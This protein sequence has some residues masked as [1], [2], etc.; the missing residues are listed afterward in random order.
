MKGLLVGTVLTLSLLVI[1]S[2]Q[3]KELSVAPLN[4]M[5]SDSIT[6]EVA[7]SMYTQYLTNGRSAKT[8]KKRTHKETPLWEAGKNFTLFNGRKALV[9]PVVE[10]TDALTLTSFDQDSLAQKPFLELFTPVKLVFYKDTQGKEHLER[11]YIKG[12]EAYA[13]RKKFRFEDADFSGRIWYEDMDDNY[14]RAFFY[15]DGKL[16]GRQVPEGEDPEKATKKNARTTY[17]CEYIYETTKTTVT[18]ISIACSSS[19]ECGPPQ[20]MYNSTSSTTT[21]WYESC[22]A[23]PDD[24]AYYSQGSGSLSYITDPGFWNFYYGL[25]AYEIAWLYLNQDKAYQFY[26]NA[27]M[28][29][30]SSQQ[31]FGG[32]VLKDED[33]TNQNAY[34]HA[35][36]AALHTR[37]W[38]DPNLALLLTNLH[39]GWTTPPDFNNLNLVEKMDYKNNALGIY[40]AI[41]CE[42]DGDALRDNI[43]T[44]IGS[45]Q[46]VRYMVNN[47]NVQELRNTT[48]ANL[49]ND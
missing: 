18:Y 49:D 48:S 43:Q 11:M 13:Q 31:R 10:A 38:N 6:V 12:D 17:T 36:L 35:Y 15:K 34:K 7:K 44:R 39:E 22:Y 29:E 9:V 3:E 1:Y 25:N 5:A 4:V 19:A 42:C 23:D 41:F 27:K 26:Q 37:A 24:P 33:G 21:V 28:A 8:V 30:V 16:I 32:A 46:G 40:A 45:G 47:I 2:C 20:F 14:L